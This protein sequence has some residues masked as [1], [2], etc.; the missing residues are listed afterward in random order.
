ML[1]YSE[2]KASECAAVG[3]LFRRNG[4]S[5]AGLFGSC[6][7]EWRPGARVGLPCLMPRHHPAGAAD[8]KAPEGTGGRTG[9]STLLRLRTSPESPGAAREPRSLALRP[10]NLVPET[11]PRITP[12][13]G[14]GGSHLPLR[15]R[16]NVDVTVWG[17][18]GLIHEIGRGAPRPYPRVSHRCGRSVEKR[19]AGIHRPARRRTVPKGGETPWLDC[20]LA[21]WRSTTAGRDPS[22]N[23][24]TAGYPR[25]SAR[26]DP[27]RT[28]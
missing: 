24:T 25:S 14:S 7:L 28:C 17:H 15:A 27:S 19:L 9:R 1:R 10:S 23:S 12:R 18:N 5:H 22:A 6:H 21:S 13:C 11:V 26:S 16:R 8:M 20:W 2:D 4:C 3:G